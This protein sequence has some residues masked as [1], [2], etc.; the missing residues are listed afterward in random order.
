MNNQNVVDNK[1]YFLKIIFILSLLVS[2]VKIESL[3]Y[4]SIDYQKRQVRTTTELIVHSAKFNIS[5][6]YKLFSSINEKLD[7]HPPVNETFSFYRYSL[8]YYDN[9]LLTHYKVF[10]N[11]FISHSQIVY[12][13]HKNNISHQSSDE[14]FLLLS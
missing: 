1:N 10:N 9:F 13:L 11:N 4:S 12:T 5:G 3:V 6:F 7:I 14:E 8:F 2:L